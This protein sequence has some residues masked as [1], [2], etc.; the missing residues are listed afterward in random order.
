MSCFLRVISIFFFLILKSGIAGTVG[1]RVN[2]LPQSIQLVNIGDESVFELAAFMIDDQVQFN[3]LTFVNESTSS[4]FTPQQS[5]TLLPWVAKKVN[6]LVQIDPLLI[7][8]KDQS[9]SEIVHMAWRNAP[10]L[11][12]EL[13]SFQRHGAHVTIRHAPQTTRPYRRTWAISVP[14]KGI[15]ELAKTPET[16]LWPPAPPVEIVWNAAHIADQS[17][18]I[19]TGPGQG[20]IW[21]VH[22]SHDGKLS[23]QVIGNGIAMG[24]E[25][26]PLWLMFFKNHGF[27]LALGLIVFGL[28]LALGIRLMD[29]ASKWG[30]LRGVGRL[31]FGSGARR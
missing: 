14:L 26:K 23:L 18:T 19:D 5:K 6:P 12:P 22:E 15:A 3:K 10:P 1:F 29:G 30:W 4:G 27:E 21:L 31:G 24:S 7:R 2:Y 28:F 11:P 25:Q 17:L 16:A 8:F 9:G 20:G 13:L